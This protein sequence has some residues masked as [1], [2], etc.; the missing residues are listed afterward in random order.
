M[1]TPDK[2][3]YRVN[4]IHCKYMMALG[5]WGLNQKEKSA[6]LLKE[7]EKLDINHQGIYIA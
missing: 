1:P 5:Y 3:F 6:R 2:I 7:V 4:I